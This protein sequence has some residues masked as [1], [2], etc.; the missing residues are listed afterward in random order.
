[1]LQVFAEVVLG[2]GEAIVSGLVP[3]A[4]L[5]F[6]APKSALD[7]PE[8]G[9]SRHSSCRGLW[10]QIQWMDCSILVTWMHDSG[11]ICA[12]KEVKCQGA[13]LKVTIDCDDRI[14]CLPH[15]LVMMLRGF[16]I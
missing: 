16:I 5:S 14:E 11:L 2:L 1:M 13:R 8:V 3:G 12:G 6:K 15:V 9:V 4:A 7:K 10:F